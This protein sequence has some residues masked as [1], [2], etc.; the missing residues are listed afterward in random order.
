MLTRK[1]RAMKTGVMIFAL[2]ILLQAC[3]TYQA[4]QRLNTWQNQVFTLASALEPMRLKLKERCANA[5]DT[6]RK[7]LARP[8]I[9]DSARRI[10][11]YLNQIEPV[12]LYMK[13][14][15]AAMEDALVV[16]GDIVEPVALPRETDAFDGCTIRAGRPLDQPVT[17]GGP[18][19]A[20][21]ADNW[22]FQW[23]P[24]AKEGTQ[25]A[26]DVLDKYLPQD[27]RM[28][29]IYWLSNSMKALGDALDEQAD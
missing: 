18:S 14:H 23:A 26:N 7:V 20:N 19:P 29:E 28:S 4:Q 25:I 8:A 10:V 9:L 24:S 11:D 1:Q 22:V 13:Q 27:Q 5:P 16:L 15:N 12:K 6:L 21:A 17:F 2:C 3:A